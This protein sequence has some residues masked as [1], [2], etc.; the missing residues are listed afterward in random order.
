M[1]KQNE[2]EW[3]RYQDRMKAERDHVQRMND[4]YENGELVGQIHA[5]QRLLKLPITSRA[6]LLALPFE[7]LKAKA[8]A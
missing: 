1:L 6:E 5:C 2:L 4:A 8:A 3:H 7:E